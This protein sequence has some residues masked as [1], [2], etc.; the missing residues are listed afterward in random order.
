MAIDRRAANR[1]LWL[2][3]TM[4]L[5]AVIQAVTWTFLDLG[6]GSVMRIGLVIAF[7]FCAVCFILVAVRARRTLRDSI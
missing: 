6:A 2:L 3:S 7:L 5:F 1:T 4:G